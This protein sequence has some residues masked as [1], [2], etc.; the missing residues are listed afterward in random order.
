MLCGYASS[1]EITPF[2]VTGV[3][4][5]VYVRYFTDEYIDEYAGVETSRREGTTAEQGLD[6]TVHSFIYHPNFFRLDFGGGPVFIQQTYD[7]TL[8]DNSNK[9]EFLNLHADANI[10]EKKP[11]PLRLYYDRHSSTTPYAVQDRMLL[12]S[13]K[14]GLKFKLRRPLLPALVLFDLSSSKIDGENLQ[15]ITDE[16][17]D[18]AL[19]KVSGDLGSNGDGSMSYSWTKDNSASGSVSRPIIETIKIT[20][21]FDAWTE[22]KFGGDEWIR[23]TNKFLFKEQDNLPNLEELRYVP[24]LYLTH[25]KNLRSS[26]RYSYLDRSVEGIDTRAHGLDGGVSHTSFD[27]RLDTNIDLH[28][29][30]ID[31]VGVEQRF[32]Q[33]DVNLSYL[34]PFDAFNIRYTGGWGIDY[35]DRVT[36]GDTVV[37]IIAEPHTVD[38]RTLSFRLDN[39]NVVEASIVVK[40]VA[41]VPFGETDYRVV[42]IGEIT[43]IQWLAPLIPNDP[44]NPDQMDVMVDYVFQSGGTADYFSYRQ[45]YGMELTK[46][47]YLRLF[48]RYRSTDHNLQS[49]LPSVPLNSKET[50][51]VGLH[52]DYPLRN[53]WTVGGKAEHENHDAD[54]GSYRRNSAG[55]Y[56]QIP[57]ILKGNL[58]L[59]A[60]R[61]LVDHLESPED[62][63]LT[64]FGLRYHARLW[65][66]TTLTADLVDEE[67]IGGTLERAYTRAD[68]RFGWAY[69]QLNFSAEARYFA[70]KTG[71]SERNQSSINLLLSRRF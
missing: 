24:N 52:V 65:N 42:T 29:D 46:G 61:L 27:D 53:T 55:V 36:E 31:T 25:A 22:H 11:Y 44:N 57:K 34:Q 21:L 47:N 67:D 54:V 8:V 39:K 58:R 40:D 9:E 15:R 38:I 48:A 45:L 69:R 64:R 43:E 70:D 59:Y 10:L 5:E 66:R 62:V 49:G 33:G 2:Q 18:R 28:A 35:T 19:L 14:Y 1:E 56:L 26:Y 63:D 68:V 3:D 30:T 16:A 32:Y 12:T 13:E 51:T 71:E 4:G 41:G 6:L 23:L 60:D 37:P 50:A 7:S 17:T 20:R